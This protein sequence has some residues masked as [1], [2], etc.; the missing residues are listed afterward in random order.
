MCIVTC[1]FVLASQY[2]WAIHY[3]GFTKAF[4]KAIC[5]QAVGGKILLALRHLKKKKIEVWPV[6]LAKKTHTHTFFFLFCFENFFFIFCVVVINVSDYS[7]N[8][9][10][11]LHFSPNWDGEIKRNAVC[12]I[13]QS[14]SVDFDETYVVM[15]KLETSKYGFS[16]MQPCLIIRL[17][18]HDEHII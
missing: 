18:D 8:Q 7:T 4:L 10:V 2:I 3:S 17:P 6:T 12:F 13:D 11:L 5:N 14:G 1:K 15:L 9:Q 16:T